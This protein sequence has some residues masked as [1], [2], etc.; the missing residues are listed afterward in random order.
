MFKAVKSGKIRFGEGLEQLQCANIFKL[1]ED[2]LTAAV[3]SRLLYL[4]SDV[5]S[6]LLLPPEL[7]LT[8]GEVKE[9]NFWPSWTVR[10]RNAVATRVEPDV[11][12]QFENVDLIVEAKI[13]DDPC[14]TPE[15]WAQEW[16]AWHQGEYSNR[17]KQV[18]LLAIGGLGATNANPGALATEIGAAAN[19]LLQINFVG[20]PAMQWV[21]LSWQEVY[22]RLSSEVLPN[23][24]IARDLA[25]ILRYFGL[26]RYQFLN[27]LSGL[28]RRLMINS[29]SGGSLDVMGRWHATRREPHWLETSRASRP[30][31]ASSMDIFR[32]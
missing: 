15:Q 25:E 10:S 16:A 13:N 5:I 8:L 18:Y 14:Q 6:A 19:S 31:S 23:S 28:R 26:R 20:V 2:F 11:Y 17:K 7:D 4:P 1:N 24:Q 29:I 12:I 22:Y 32:R 3:F 9:S 30:I 21:G 27:D